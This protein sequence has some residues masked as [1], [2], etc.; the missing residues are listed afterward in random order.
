MHISKKSF[1]VRVVRHWHSLRREMVEALSLK[2]F[3]VRL[4][5]TLSTLM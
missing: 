5:Q 1:T 3:E 4:D 2:T